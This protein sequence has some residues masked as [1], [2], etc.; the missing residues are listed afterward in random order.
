VTFH[1]GDAFGPQDVIDTWKMIMNEEFAA[2]DK[3]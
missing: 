3:R 2:Y 1:N